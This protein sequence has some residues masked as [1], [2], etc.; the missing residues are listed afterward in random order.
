MSNIAIKVEN[1]SKIYR[2]GEIGTGSIG[3]DVDRWFKTKILGKEDP[4]YTTEN[5]EKE[6]AYFSEIGFKVHRFEGKHDVDS[7]T[8]L[9]IL[10]N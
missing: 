8:L 5:Q 2:L 10:G 4:Y 1:L 9:S 6:C 7:A 3:Q